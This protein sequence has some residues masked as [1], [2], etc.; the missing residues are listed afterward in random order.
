M[1]LPVIAGLSSGVAMIIAL[2]VFSGADSKQT[3]SVSGLKITYSSLPSDFSVVYAYGVYGK[4]VLDSTSGTISIDMV[5]KPP[6]VIDFVLSKQDMAR[7]WNATMSNDFFTLPNMTDACPS[8]AGCKMVTPEQDYS[9][10]ITANGQR[11][12]VALT[13]IYELNHADD[14]NLEKFKAVSG[15]IQDILSHSPRLEG[16]PK[17]PCGYQ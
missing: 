7:I 13:E 11:H 8:V 1:T 6:L 5:C 14:K 2:I 4:N 16:Q 9:L 10:S 3:Y 15:T 12:M 17:P